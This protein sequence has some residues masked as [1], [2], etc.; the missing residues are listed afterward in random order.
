MLRS[1]VISGIDT[2]RLSNAVS[3]PG[4]D[5]RIWVSYAVLLD[6]P[7]LDTEPDGKD[8]VADIMLLPS[9]TVETARVG[10][11]Y[12]GN[13]F[14]FYAPLHK[15][16][17]VLVVAPSG[18]PDEGLVITQRFWSPAD[19]P[20]EGLDIEEL[21]LVVESGKNLRIKAQGAGNVY[22]A[23]DAGKLYLGSPDGTEPVAKG[24][25]LKA[26]L[27]DIVLKLNTHVH[28]SAAPGVP[29]SPCTSAV[30]P[31]VFIG[32]TPAILATTTE[33]K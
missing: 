14:G 16:D 23:V 6:D 11:L 9:G 17:E 2:E 3:R 30:P 4:I 25:S 10:T 29:T 27:D 7:V 26:Y 18:D 33:V 5:P 21:T 28:T 22:L 19:P 12:A 15:D 8:V 1:R 24:T 13:G 31:T 32:P 20:P